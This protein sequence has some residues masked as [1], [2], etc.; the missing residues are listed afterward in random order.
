MQSLLHLELENEARVAGLRLLLCLHDLVQEILVVLSRILLLACLELRV[1]LTHQVLENGG[2]DAI[3]IV[4]VRSEGLCLLFFAH[5]VM[6]HFLSKLFLT[7]LSRKESLRQLLDLTLEALGG[8]F[9]A[10]S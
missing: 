5:L 2:P 9:V 8:E 10:L 7:V 6:Y 1:T 3:L 4:L